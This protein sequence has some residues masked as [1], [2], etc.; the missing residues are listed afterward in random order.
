MSTPIHVSVAWPYANG[1]LHVGHLAGALLPAD[2]FARYHRLQGHR[3]LMVSGSD[4]HGTPLTLE[5]DRRGLSPR[6]LFEHYHHRFLE[7]QSALGL[8]YDVFTHTDTENHHRVAQEVFLRL[9]RAGYLSRQH[10]VQLYTERAGR[11]LPD[12]YVEGT[13][14]YCGAHDARGDQCDQCS[15]QLEATELLNPRCTLDGSRPVLRHT[16]HW[17]FDL[18]PFTNRL[19]QYCEQHAH[20]WRPSVLNFSRAYIR[21]G[22]HSRP[23]TRDLDWGIPIPLPGWDDKCLY[24]WFEALLGYISA[25]IEWASTT[26]QPEVWKAW[27]N[28]PA[29]RIY[30]FLRKDNIPFHTVLWPALLLGVGT[31][32]DDD[33]TARLNLPHDVPANAFMTLDNAQFSKSRQHAV[34]L[35]DL[36]AQYDP[37]VIRYAV[38][39]MMPE[40]DDTDFSWTAF[41]RHTNAELIAA[42]GNLVHRVMT[43]AVTHWDGHVPAPG[44]LT[45][46]DQALL[47][48]VEQGFAAV[49]AL[50]EAVKLRAAL[51]EAMDL[52]RAVNGYLARAPWFSVIRTDTTTAATT[53]YSALH[54]IDSLSV[55]LAPFVPFGAERVHRALGYT[56]PLFGTQRIVTVT[57]QVRSHDAL[58]YDATGAMGRWM[59]SAL[60]PGQRLAWSTPL[61]RKL[62]APTVEVD[63]AR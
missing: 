22:L 52:V 6:S 58:V 63:G 18:A 36:V 33:D 23:I 16:E 13:C 45:S 30:N 31:L 29:A 7:T 1:D 56:R 17:Y 39:A 55:L 37:D 46:I 43:F 21:R 25:S 41:V 38:A 20:H 11:F 5:A 8:S 44:V 60:A 61:Y 48:Q 35:P 28:N 19:L 51:H 32:N 59:P 34:W 40:R 9:Y 24:V 50:L 42:W 10:H 27:W 15:T 54:A 47:T 14:P 26:G 62:E 57:E 2:I 49:G 12:R 53:V 4:A 3:V